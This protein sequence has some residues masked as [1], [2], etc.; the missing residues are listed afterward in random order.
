[1]QQLTIRLAL[2]RADLAP[3]RYRSFLSHGVERIFLREV[4]TRFQFLH[5]LVLDHFAG[6]HALGQLDSA[7]MLVDRGAWSPT[8]MI[9]D[10]RA[11]V[12]AVW[13]IDE[14][15][16]ISVMSPLHD[17][18]RRDISAFISDPG[19]V[20]LLGSSE[21][22][23]QGVLVFNFLIDYVRTRVT[24]LSDAGNNL[25]AQ[26]GVVLLA[27]LVARIGSK[28]DQASSCLI[29]AEVAGLPP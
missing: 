1:V 7:W 4:G 18:Y 2:A 20:D 27:R 10:I 25:F 26:E 14:P 24:W 3:W 9:E 6:L 23:I 16:T 28:E 19:L 22:K 12:D 17:K 11:V 15:S 21:R 5:R 13:L 8:R 29:L